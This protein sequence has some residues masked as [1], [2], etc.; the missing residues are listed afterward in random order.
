[1]S[2]TITITLDKK[3]ASSVR[4]ALDSFASDIVRNSNGVNAA[5]QY[6]DSFRSISNRISSNLMKIDESSE[7]E[8]IAHDP[9]NPNATVNKA[10]KRNTRSHVHKS[11]AVNIIKNNY[12]GFGGKLSL[13]E[14]AKLGG[15]TFATANTYMSLIRKEAKIIANSMCIDFKEA[16]KAV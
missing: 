13:T 1:M 3:E 12:V 8:E 9:S 2:N 11:A 14:C 10:V 6:A 7:V 16:L 5:I 4:L 15:V